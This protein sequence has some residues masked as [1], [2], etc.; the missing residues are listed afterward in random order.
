MGL[1]LDELEE[2]EKYT[3][4]EKDIDVLYDEKIENYLQSQNAITVDFKK[5]QYGS[6]FV[7]LGGSTC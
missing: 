7:I 3:I 1:V 4:K 6:G 5:D 2:N